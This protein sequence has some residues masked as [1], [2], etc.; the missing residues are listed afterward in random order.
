MEM[1]IGLQLYTI[2]DQ[3]H[4]GY[5]ELLKRVAKI[6]YAGFE[7][8]YNPK[9]AEEIG[10]LAK[11]YSLKIVSAGVGADS[12]ENDYGNV[13]DFMKQVD[14]DIMIM[15]FGE[16]DMDTLE[17]AL[18][19]A[20]R[21]D[22]LAKKVEKDGYTLAC[23]N[24][25]WEFTKRFDGK[26]AT[27]IFMENSETFKL[28]LD[29]GWAFYAGADVARYIDELG[30][31]IALLHIKDVTADKKLTEIGSGAADMKKILYAA[32]SAGI[33]WGMVEQDDN[34]KVSSFDSI[35]TSYDYLKSI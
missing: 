4:L 15:G 24:H 25:W 16:G 13:K 3:M 18:K 27:D 10:G 35:K 2:R 11:K 12:I 5:D 34:F 22:R 20:E 29:I 1:N 32:C 19:I 26:T 14:T 7:T 30:D 21:L 23:H 31:R 6:G 9:T 17:K 28:E 8:G 33:K